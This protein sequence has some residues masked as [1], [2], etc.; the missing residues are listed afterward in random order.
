VWN[1]QQGSTQIL[2]TDT[3]AQRAAKKKQA[4]GRRTYQRRKCAREFILWRAP[5]SMLAR[6]EQEE[7][8]NAGKQS[9]Q[10]FNAKSK[11]KGKR[12]A[13]MSRKVGVIKL[14]TLENCV[15][16]RFAAHAV[17]FRHTGHA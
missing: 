13:G 2:S 8:L 10:N 1:L 14:S 5:K 7:K 3:P 6:R 11:G 17:N 15:T 4:K 16:R 12:Q 9:W